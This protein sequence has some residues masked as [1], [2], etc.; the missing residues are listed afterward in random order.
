MSVYL[1]DNTTLLAKLDAALGARNVH[2]FRSLLHA[3]KGSSASMGTDR[4]TEMC[5]E[6]GRLSDAEIRL[7][8][9]ALGKALSGELGA[10]RAAL[11]AYLRNKQRSAS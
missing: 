10:A 11:D 1:A 7:Q 3:M 5:T 6:I 8:A 9:P 4:L 2:E